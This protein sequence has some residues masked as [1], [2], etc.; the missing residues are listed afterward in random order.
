MATTVT[1]EV[2]I[3]HPSKKLYRFTVLGFVASLSFGSYFAYDIVSGIAP[4]LVEDLNVAR[5]T[6]GAFFTAYSVAAVLAVL[7]GGMLIDRLGTRKAS[8]LF[9]VLV[10][11]GA[12]IVW[13]AKSVPVLFAGRFIFGA[14]SEPLIVAQST[15]LA[16]WF[17]DK[18]LALSFGITLTVSRFGSLFA[19]NTGELF[20]SFFGSYRYAL[21]V[22]VAACG[23]SLLG[24]LAYIVL[25]RRGE[26][27]LQLKD[28]NAGDKIVLKDIK[29][30]KPT[31]WYVTFLCLTFYSAIFPFT[32]LSTDFFVDKWGV[33]R[34]PRPAV[35]F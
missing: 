19:F 9:S 24:N 29:E 23:I 20:S 26:H 34:L 11:S 8:L 5:G 17:K 31:F 22:A 25:D 13:M 1:G 27:V 28:E 16:R 2:G 4:R 33:A 7:I 21:L 30:F 6:I 32:N 18:E 10:F 12:G 14:G 15:I 35:G 3:F